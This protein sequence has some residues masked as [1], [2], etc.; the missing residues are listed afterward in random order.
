MAARIVSVN[1]DDIN[2]DTNT[3]CVDCMFNPFEYTVSKTNQFKETATQPLDNKPQAEFVKAGAQTL[4]LNLVFDTYET[5]ENVSDKTNELWEFM[6]ITVKKIGK[7]EVKIPPP[8]AAFEWGG[9]FRFVAYITNM[10]QKFTLLKRRDTRSRKCDYNLHP[11]PR[12]RRLWQPKP[13][14]YFGWRPC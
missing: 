12:Y 2:L 3:V 10:T 14:S 1:P 4:T 7:K 11:I 6:K 9:G 5:G 8:L 13:E